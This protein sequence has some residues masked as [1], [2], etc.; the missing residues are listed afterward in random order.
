MKHNYFEENHIRD[1]IEDCLPEVSDMPSLCYSVMREIKGEGKV[2]KK[3][4]LGLVLA[5]VL[6]L[7]TVS[8]LAAITMNAHYESLIEVESGNGV[9]SGWSVEDKLALIDLMLDTGIEL[10]EDQL[11]QLRSGALTKREQGKLATK[12]IASYYPPRTNDFTT[13]D[14]LAKEYGRYD[15]WPLELKAWHSSLREKYGYSELYGG[16][17]MAVLP[18][19]GDLSEEEAIQHGHNCLTEIVGL[20]YSYIDTLYLSISFEESS[21][22]GSRSWLLNY[23]EK[24]DIEFQ[25]VIAYVYFSNDGKHNQCGLGK[26]IGERVSEEFEDLLTNHRDTFLTVEGLAAFAQDLAPRINEALDN[27][28]N[29][30]NWPKRF[31]K[32]PYAYPAIGSIPQDEA[33]QMATEAACQYLGFTKQQLLENYQMSLSYRVYAETGD[34]YRLCFYISEKENSEALSRFREGEFPF[35][36][37]IRMN[38]FTGEVFDMQESNNRSINQLGE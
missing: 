15:T 31:A 4:S 3:I 2:K 38:A 6:I 12:I 17:S 1:A 26:E 30:K 27:D 24:D 16:S 5:I 25:D 34:E 35:C 14:I 10:D 18:G 22:D 11:T 19:D 21:I 33:I 9:I 29:V 23:Y 28:E 36:V 37:I 20:E 8:A 7:I 32:I 13:V